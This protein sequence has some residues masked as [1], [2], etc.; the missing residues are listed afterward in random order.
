MY[1]P[2]PRLSVHYLVVLNIAVT[3]EYKNPI[4]EA[5]VLL[6]LENFLDSGYIEKL[7]DI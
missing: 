2:S 7:H 5:N 1:H 3:V 6:I 4:S